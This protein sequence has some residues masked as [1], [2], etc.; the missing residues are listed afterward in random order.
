V[1]DYPMNH[2]RTPEPNL[3]FVQKVRQ[4]WLRFRY[5]DPVQ[6]AAQD[7]VHDDLARVEARLES[8]AAE[9]ESV[10][11]Q[12]LMELDRR[13][14]LLGPGRSAPAWSSMIQGLVAAVTIFGTL[15]LAVFNGWFNAVMTMVDDETGA[16]RWVTQQQVSE[17]VSA[18]QTPIMWALFGMLTLVVLTLIGAAEKDGKRGVSR[19]W[20]KEFSASEMS[21]SKA[22]VEGGDDAFWDAVRRMP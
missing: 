11:R 20:L 21:R 12:V 9:D 10:R 2:P 13:I 4:T 3:N 17:T 8:F 5:R 14:E 15:L 1:D 7:H 18:V 22:E 19:A 6:R 16:L